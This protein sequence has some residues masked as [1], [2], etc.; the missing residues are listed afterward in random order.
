MH[1]IQGAVRIPMPLHDTGIDRLQVVKEVGHD[2]R[3]VV[4]GNVGYHHV[5]VLPLRTGGGGSGVEGP[6]PRPASLDRRRHVVAN[7]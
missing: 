6:L 4:R 3:H 2:A 7:G 1:Q 5:G